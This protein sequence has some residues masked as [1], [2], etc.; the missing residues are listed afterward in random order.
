MTDTENQQPVM[1]QESLQSTARVLPKP[2]KA[3]RGRLAELMIYIMLVL[4]G[5]LLAVASAY[6][7]RKFGF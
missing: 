1:R 5:V 3:R 4:A 6:L 2:K 7:M